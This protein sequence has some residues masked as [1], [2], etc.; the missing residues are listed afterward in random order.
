M[1]W[2][3]YNAKFAGQVAGGLKGKKRPSGPRYLVRFEEKDWSA[4]RIVWA[5][6]R[7]TDPKEKFVDHIDGNALNNNPKNLRLVDTCQNIYN[8]KIGSRNSS[9]FRGVVQKS[10][11]RWQARIRHK[12]TEVCL[13][14]FDSFEDAV[15]ARI[16]GELKYHGEF[17]MYASRKEK[18]R[19]GLPLDVFC[20]MI[21]NHVD[22]LFRKRRKKL[23]IK[24]DSGE[25]IRQV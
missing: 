8:Q 19:N 25:A 13:G 9:G 16:A 4:S 22:K 14:I 6:T 5:I 3:V 21:Q 10:A 24:N 20:A 1:A 18:Y 7:G 11:H 23:G 15:E 12:K 2:G 17:S